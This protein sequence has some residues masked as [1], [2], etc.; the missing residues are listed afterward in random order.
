MQECPL[1]RQACRGPHRASVGD[2]F[3]DQLGNVEH[4]IG[5]G[6][7]GIDR[8][9]YLAFADADDVIEALVLLGVT[10][11]KDRADDLPP[12]RR[13]RPT[14]PMPLEHDRR[15]VIGLDDST[16]VRPKRPRYAASAR[17]VRTPEATADR[18]LTTALGKEQVL[19][20]PVL[21]TDHPALGIRE[22]DPI[23]RLESQ[24]SSCGGILFL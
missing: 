4:E 3:P 24:L 10:E 11:M 1:S 12:P 20:P 9:A 19:F 2:G 22:T 18:A 5:L 23:E 16:E 14:V 21:E 13:V 7:I 15:A 17:E 8:R 6:L